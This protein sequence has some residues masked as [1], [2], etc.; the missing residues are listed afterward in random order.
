MSSSPQTK[1]TLDECVTELRK[2]RME[3][4][5]RLRDAAIREQLGLRYVGIYY[6]EFGRPPEELYLSVD[7]HHYTRRAQFTYRKLN[8]VTTAEFHRTDWD[9]VV[10]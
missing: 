1:K 9:R 2:L 5:D 8:P 6:P 4:A 7:G 10:V 3:R